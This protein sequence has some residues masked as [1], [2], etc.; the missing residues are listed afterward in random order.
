[1]D[2]RLILE[3]IN[4]HGDYLL[5]IILRR[6]DQQQNNTNM[7]DASLFQLIESY[8]TAVSQIQSSLTYSLS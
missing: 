1:M 4:R 2:A 8:P 5:H 3:C 7:T 6:L